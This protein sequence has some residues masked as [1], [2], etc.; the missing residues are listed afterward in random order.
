MEMELPQSLW[1]RY[2]TFMVNYLASGA[3]T[4][5]L[6]NNPVSK[7][8]TEVLAFAFLVV[9]SY[10]IIYWCGIYLSLWEYH[11][12]DI[13]TEVPI[14]C[15]HVFIRLNVA[16]EDSITTVR[17]Y[18]ETKR[19]NKYLP[20]NSSTK[21]YSKAFKLNTFIKYYFEFSPE[22][23]KGSKEPEFGSTIE[24][25]RLKVLDLFQNSDIYAEY[26]KE[27]PL[28]KENVLIF[29]NRLEE[30]KEVDNLNYLSKVRIE[31]GNAVDCVVIY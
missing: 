1:T 6:V 2:D 22:D 18:Y 14:H 10:E 31:T 19:K 28:T 8:I 21:L 9:L 23:F 30:I 27:T 29:N 12:K 26:H 13:F 24:H 4:G 25:L 11:A 17:E 16:P 5:N 15:A 20:W 7:Y 3:F